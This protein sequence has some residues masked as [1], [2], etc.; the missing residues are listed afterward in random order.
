MKK[1]VDYDKQAQ[2]ILSEAKSVLDSIEDDDTDLLPALTSL[3]PT[4]QRFVHMYL[5]GKHST[6]K[7]AEI[8]DVHPNTILSWLKRKDVQAAIAETQTVMNVMVAQQ[9]TNMAS[10]AV[11][12]LNSLMDSPMDMVALQAVKDVL[13]RAGHKP[14]SEMK[15]EKTVHTY[16]QKLGNLIEATISDVEYEVVDDE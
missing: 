3:Q 16:E 8:F 10:K 2:Y 4:H 5:A 15:I 9:I 14:K 12:R 6:S 11:G 1:K 7:L 13:D